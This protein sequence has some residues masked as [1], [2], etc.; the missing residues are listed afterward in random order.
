MKVRSFIGVIIGA[1]LLH[2]S[3][4]PSP[5]SVYGADTIIPFIG[6]DAA[7]FLCG[8]ARAYREAP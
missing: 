2:L 5:K 4:N 1:S 7:L 8:A 6:A 3:L